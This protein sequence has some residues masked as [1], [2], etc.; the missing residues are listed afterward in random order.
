MAQIETSAVASNG[1]TVYVVEVDGPLELPTVPVLRSELA[2]LSEEGTGRLLLDLT[3]VDFI[4]LA[5]VAAL[6]RAGLAARAIAIAVPTGSQ[7]ARTLALCRLDSTIPTF[8]DRAEA[9]AAL[10]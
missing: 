10:T 4:D 8:R 3:S 5:G 1:G 6:Y 9:F 7:P 2:R